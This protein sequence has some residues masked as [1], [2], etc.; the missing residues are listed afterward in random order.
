MESQSLGKV[1]LHLAV[2]VHWHRAYM[3][4]VQDLGTGFEEEL[5]VCIEL[6]FGV[7]NAFEEQVLFLLFF[8]V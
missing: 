4:E 5:V 1:S 2:G 8:V 3:W 6:T 7:Q